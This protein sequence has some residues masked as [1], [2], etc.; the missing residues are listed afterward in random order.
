V[1]YLI[2]QLNYKP[3]QKFQAHRHK[4]SRNRTHE[5]LIMIVVQFPSCVWTVCFSRTFRD[6]TAAWTR[7]NEALK[8][9]VQQ[10]KNYPPELDIYFGSAAYSEREKTSFM[11]ISIFLFLVCPCRGL[12][13]FFASSPTLH[14]QFTFSL[15]V[16]RSDSES[17]ACKSSIEIIVSA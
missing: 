10:F 4:S 16:F 7:D 1:A 2:C 14:R 8:D 6:S 17:S 9:M 3:S 15:P 13:H 11:Q 12:W 5:N